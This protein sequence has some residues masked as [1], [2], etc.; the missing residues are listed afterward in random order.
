MQGCDQPGH[1]DVRGPRVTDS[2]PA[3]EA[4]MWEPDSDPRSVL[5]VRRRALEGGTKAG[6]VGQRLELQGHSQ[7]RHV[8]TRTARELTST[9]QFR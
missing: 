4:V 9:N 2:S 1:Q 6:G 7:G 5:S 3:R 8:G